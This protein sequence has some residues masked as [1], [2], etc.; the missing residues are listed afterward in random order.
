ML[1]TVH[2][3]V[4]YAV[5]VLVLLAAL[6]AFKRAKDGREFDATP[7]RIVY[8]ILTLQVV[9]GIAVYGMG[10]AW[11]A[12]ELL[13]YVHPALAIAALGVGQVLLGRARRTQM[14]ADAH[15][16]AGR[17]LLLTL[18]LVL[19]AIGVASAATRI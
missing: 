9:V 6:A 17:G 15:R 14:A 19:A 2:Q 1:I 10:R 12:T 7:Y 8:G 5:S 13:A 3:Y 18:L 4:G 11:D 16:T